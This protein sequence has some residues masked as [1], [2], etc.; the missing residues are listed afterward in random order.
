MTRLVRNGGAGYHVSGMNGNRTAGAGVFTAMVDIVWRASV[1]TLVGVLTGFGANALRS[2]GVAIAE[3][4]P[5]VTCT[6]GTQGLAAFDTPPVRLVHQSEATVM[7]AEGTTLIADAR[8]AKAFAAGHIAGAIHLPCSAS[9]KV[10]LAA[11]SGLSGKRLMLVYGESTDDA[12]PVAEQMRQRLGRS[13]LR[14]GVLEGGF[15]AWSSAGLACSSG[16]CPE[17]GG[18]HDKWGLTPHA[19]G[20]GEH[21][22]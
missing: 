7:C 8:D 2:D 10:A 1:L 21:K 16:N 20:P 3:F 11:E 5:P 19:E 14:I 12:F 9:E 22:P 17:C 13:D 6:D 18:A 15:G 4:A